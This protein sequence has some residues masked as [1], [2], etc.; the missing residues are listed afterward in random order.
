MTYC[1]RMALWIGLLLAWFVVALVGGLA[2]GRVLRGLDRPVRLPSAGPASTGSATPAAR[3]PA[4]PDASDEAL[5]S[6]SRVGPRV[7]RR[8]TSAA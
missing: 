3:P 7:R 1:A 6:F 8:P 2:L 5:R 4:L